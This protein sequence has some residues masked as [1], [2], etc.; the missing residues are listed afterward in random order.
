VRSDKAVAACH[1]DIGHIYS[2]IFTGRFTF[3]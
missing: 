2:L 1:D 3:T